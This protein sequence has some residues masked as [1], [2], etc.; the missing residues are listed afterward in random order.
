MG[1][2][3]ATPPHVCYCVCTFLP[4]LKLGR[5][6][7]ACGYARDSMAVNSP[8]LMYTM[9]HLTLARQK[10]RRLTTRRLTHT[11]PLT[12]TPAVGE[13]VH[14]HAAAV[15]S[16][17]ALGPAPTTGIYKKKGC[18]ARNR[19]HVT[20]WTRRPLPPS[21]S[22]P[23]RS[24]EEGHAP[25]RRRRAPPQKPNRQNSTRR[26]SGR[27]TLAPGVFRQPS[28]YSFAGSPSRPAS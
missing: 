6:T 26:P 25:L 19:R 16:Q 27:G 28:R 14:R 15:R 8:T 24:A 9:P 1:G 2:A 10:I 18:C 17:T 13:H 12:R 4:W 23:S 3:P 21:G 20:D 22:A 11:P 5:V 7:Q